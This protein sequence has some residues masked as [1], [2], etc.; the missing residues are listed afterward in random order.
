VRQILLNLLG[1]AVKFT[2]AGSVELSVVESHNALVFSVSDTGPGIPLEDRDHVFEPFTQLG[3]DKTREYG[4]T[5]LGL[6][7]TKRL[8]DLLHGDI[9]ANARDGGGSTFVVSLPYQ[10][11]S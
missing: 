9:R 10:R 3:A 1:N 2:P 4:S 5:G 7:I 11:A 8:V 6:A